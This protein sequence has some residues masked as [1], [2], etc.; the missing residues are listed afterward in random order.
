MYH[1]RF[2]L[3]LNTH[4]WLNTNEINFPAAIFPHFVHD[5]LWKETLSQTVKKEHKT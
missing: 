4:T 3:S 1:V 5:D 2:W